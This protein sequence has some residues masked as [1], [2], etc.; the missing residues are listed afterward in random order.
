[1]R[2]F[3]LIAIVFVSLCV[4]IPFLQIPNTFLPQNKTVQGIEISNE[5]I[6]VNINVLPAE[7]MEGRNITI[8]FQ[9][10]NKASYNLENVKLNLYDPCVFSGSGT[11]KVIGTLR[12]N[13]TNSSSLVLKAGSVTLPRDCEM[14]FRVEYEGKF[15]LSQDIAVL[16]EPE[17]NVRL[18]QGTLKSVPIGSL[19]SISP[20]K[21]SLTLTQEQP[22][23]SET[24]TD[25]EINY[26]YIGDG[27]IN[28]TSV[29]IKVP[30]NLQYLSCTDYTYAGGTLSLNKALKFINKRAN[31]SI[32]TFKTKANSP[33]DIE[34][35]FLT[36]RYKYI[37]DNS[38]TVR[39]KE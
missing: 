18:L 33:M 8:M 36:A 4:E 22:L 16:T 7:V 21:I 13:Q 37:L 1:M 32:C 28:V 3:L 25:M 39:V 19:S 10:M 12:P 20:L 17:Y 29:V 35:L 34:S 38:I 2:Y 26:I 14:K 27:F 11:E 9:V 23:L 31:P 5:D 24:T 15:S 6:Y 30:D